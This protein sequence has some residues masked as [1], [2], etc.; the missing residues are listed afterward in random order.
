M[1][2]PRYPIGKFVEPVDPTPES[3]DG[4]IRQIEEAPQRL[5]DAVRGLTA[6]Q[7]DTPYREGGWTARQVVHHMA[8]SH[9]NAYI[10]H[11]LAVTEDRPTI[12]P[13]KE[14]EWA[15]LS[16]GKRAAAEI[17]LNLLAALHE[18]WVLFLRAL[19]EEMFART[20]VHPAMPEPVSLDQNIVMYA[21]HGRHH[22]AQID[23]LRRRSGW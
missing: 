9:M 10:R 19:P 21:W 3:R 12:R 17:S 16:D 23:A 20:F 8:D 4:L 1:I 13:Y 22:V 15:E 18:R 11:K 14:A 5:R 6:A 7:L 2:D